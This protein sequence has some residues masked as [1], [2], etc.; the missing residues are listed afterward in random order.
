M[1]SIPALEKLSA[2]HPN[3]FHTVG[4]HPHDSIGM[5]DE[6]LA[7]LEKASRHPKCRAIGEI[8]LDYHYDHSPRDVQIRRLR[9]QLE[10]AA[11]V[12]Q[13]VV[14]HSREAEDE[15]LAALTRL[16]PGA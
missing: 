13:P 11:R 5:K 12:G 4:V 9:E 8:G 2:S 3:V 15:L 6:D 14:I 7:A 1:A 16:R 10:L